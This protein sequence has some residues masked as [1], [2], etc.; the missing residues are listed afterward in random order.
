MDSLSRFI[1]NGES[2]EENGNNKD[3]QFWQQ[4]NK[5]TEIKD[6][7]MFDKTLDYIHQN[8]PT[9]GRSGLAGLVIK[10]ED[11]KYSTCA[12]AAFSLKTYNYNSVALKY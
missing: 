12:N 8:L 11:W 9:A 4:H 3:W 1:G 10:E 7:Q 6:Q 2:R 5:P